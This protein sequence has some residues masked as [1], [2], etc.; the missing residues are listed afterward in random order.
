MAKTHSVA[1]YTISVRKKKSKEDKDPQL[2]PVD[3]KIGEIGSLTDFIDEY[4]KKYK[5]EMFSDGKTEKHLKI[6][7]YNKYKTKKYYLDGEVS[8]GESGL[9]ST[10]QHLETNQIYEKTPEE[11]DLLPFYFCFRQTTDDTKL[12]LCT[13]RYGNQGIKD[14]LQKSLVAF[15]NKNFEEYKIEIDDHLPAFLKK[16]FFGNNVVDKVEFT[17]LEDDIGDVSSVLES[18]GRRELQKGRAKVKISLQPASGV[19]YAFKEKYIDNPMAA[20]AEMYPKK[21]SID[22]SKRVGASVTFRNTDGKKRTF[23]I[24]QEKDILPY[25]NIAGK[26]SL[27]SKRHPVFEDMQKV[28]SDILVEAKLIVE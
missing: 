3:E 10:L 26:V 6:S 16:Q 13:L 2:L 25:V 1:I 19:V 18:E 22:E 23:S 8:C 12:A 7:K 24:L 28:V 4:C 20:L 11:V 21:I 15:F 17:Y 27:D 9:G 5:N 14:Q